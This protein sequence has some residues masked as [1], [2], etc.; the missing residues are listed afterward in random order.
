[1]ASRKITNGC[2]LWTKSGKRTAWLELGPAKAQAY[3][4]GEILGLFFLAMIP[5]PWGP[6]IVV[7]AK[8]RHAVVNN[9][10]GP[11]GTFIKFDFTGPVAARARTD[12]NKGREPSPW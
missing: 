10:L 5:A 12:A 3:A 11:K 8:L 6:I 9:N 4:R 7:A 2:V 1:M